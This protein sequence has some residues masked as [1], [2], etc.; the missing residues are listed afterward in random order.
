MKVILTA[1]EWI[2][3]PDGTSEATSGRLVWRSFGLLAHSG[4]PSR[5]REGVA[6]STF[7]SGSGITRPWVVA[8]W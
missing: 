3:R 5:A 8:L 1:Y 6:M 7:S 2:V 4:S